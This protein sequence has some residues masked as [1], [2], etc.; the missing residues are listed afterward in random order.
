M[1]RGI[2]S[3]FNACLNLLKNAVRRVGRDNQPD[4]PRTS[5]EGRFQ[6]VLSSA[7]ERIADP[8]TGSDKGLRIADYFNNPVR[9][10]F[11]MDIKSDRKAIE[12]QQEITETVGATN[13]ARDPQ[14]GD[15]SSGASARRRFRKSVVS[16]QTALLRQKIDT[17]I[18]RAAKRYEL[19]P[20]LI[21]GIIEAESS[22]RPEAVSP[23]GARGLMQLMPATA[24]ELGV[25]D[26][27]DIN[28]NID[29]GAKYLKKMM[30]IFDGD[31][32][33][34]LAAYN[35]G[36]GTVRRFNGEVPYSE[37]R[38]YVQRVLKYSE[39]KA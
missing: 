36:P 32:G 22:F 30:D 28:Q 3:R 4:C 7:Q 23:A 10:G 2:S 13:S 27:F 26:P 12:C 33:R 38:N 34:A 29:G 5:A 14:Q 31:T 35:A 24:R 39:L 8:D 17:A 6:Q 15:P 11:G 20:S 21:R 37:T 19:P 25:T 16:E 9:A 1:N 18:A